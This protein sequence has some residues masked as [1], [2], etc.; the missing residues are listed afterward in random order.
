MAEGIP[1]QEELFD[2]ES[3][4]EHSDEKGLTY[5]AEVD[6]DR[7][8]V[9]IIVNPKGWDER[10]ISFVPVIKGGRFFGLHKEGG[11]VSDVEHAK[12]CE[13]ASKIFED[14]YAS[15]RFSASAEG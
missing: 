13:I 7:P 8:A 11:W 12:A 6:R 2:S 10:Y 3:Y 9:K 15:G 5:V 4:V 14:G 1:G